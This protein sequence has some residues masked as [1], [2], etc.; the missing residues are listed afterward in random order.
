M[1]I[2]FLFIF[3]PVFDE[4]YGLVYGSTTIFIG[5]LFIIVG[6]CF[7][8]LRHQNQTNMEKYE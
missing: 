8:D 6:I 5:V 7:P 4:D 3:G 2:G 1:G